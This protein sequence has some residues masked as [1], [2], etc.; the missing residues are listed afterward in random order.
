MVENTYI[1]QVPIC[2]T[3][4]PFI[5]SSLCPSLPPVMPQT[6]QSSV[7]NTVVF[8]LVSHGTL[9]SNSIETQKVKEAV[10]WTERAQS[11]NCSSTAPLSFYRGGKLW[12]P[13]RGSGPAY[14]PKKSWCQIRRRTR[15]PSCPASISPLYSRDRKLFFTGKERESEY[16]TPTTLPLR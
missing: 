2:D 14:G 3:G 8:T 16:I 7:T 5:G 9:S 6:H 1:L 10:G 15:Y 11:E 13:E 4:E 12:S